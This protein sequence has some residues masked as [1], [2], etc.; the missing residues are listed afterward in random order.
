M[1]SRIA[2]ANAAD[3]RDKQRIGDEVDDG[4]GDEVNDVLVGVKCP[5]KVDADFL[6]I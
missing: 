3:D 1:A 6:L 2:V 5:A 4:D